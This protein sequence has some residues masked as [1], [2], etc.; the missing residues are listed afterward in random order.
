VLEYED[1]KL[2]DSASSC[3]LNNRLLFTV[4]PEFN[5]DHGTYHLGLGVVDFDNVSSLVNRSQPVYSG[6]YSGFKTL[7]LVSGTV[8]GVDRAWAY[9][10]GPTNNIEL[11]ELD[12]DALFDGDEHKDRIEWSFETGCFDFKYDNELKRIESC[13]IWY[14]TLAGSVCFKLYYK[15]DQYPNW[16]LWKS[17]TENA[18]YGQPV[19]ALGQMPPVQYRCRRTIGPPDSLDNTFDG[20]PARFGF[21]FQLKLEVTGPARIKRI[22][23]KAQREI[24]PEYGP[25]P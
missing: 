13:E 19:P 3:L 23:V 18:P 24:E 25:L 6:I 12:T 21:D 9:V 20:R 10:L 16:F 11:W 15:A 7:Q 17:W 14:D 1:Q 4:M 2:L 22:R 8:D 5:S